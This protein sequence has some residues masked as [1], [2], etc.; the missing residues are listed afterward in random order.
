[1]HEAIDH[2]VRQTSIS[3]GSKNDDRHY[4]EEAGGGA[5][6]KEFCREFCGHGNHGGG[7]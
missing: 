4:E 6:G 3:S 7:R 2:G 5:H 1:I